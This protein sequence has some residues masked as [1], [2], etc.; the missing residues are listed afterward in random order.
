MIGANVSPDLH[1]DQQGGVHVE[2]SI[3]PDGQA[4]IAET[5]TEKA[6]AKISEAGVLKAADDF[7][8]YGTG[9]YRVFTEITYS[10]GYT[11]DNHSNA[12]IVITLGIGGCTDPIA[13]NYDP[14]ATCQCVT[15]LFTYCCSTPV[16]TLDL[17]NGI[18]NQSLECEVQCDPAADDG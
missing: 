18:C 13:T 9:Q 6:T 5:M 14:A 2:F 4:L 1:I 11:C 16:L 3:D 15:C 8:G 10:N 7:G 12:S 17:T